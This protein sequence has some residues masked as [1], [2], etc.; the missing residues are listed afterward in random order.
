MVVLDEGDVDAGGAVARRVVGLDEEAA[1]VA[2]DPRLD[3]QD[4]G[5]A[6]SG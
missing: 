2:E 5:Q 1:V 6:R 4:V 3:D